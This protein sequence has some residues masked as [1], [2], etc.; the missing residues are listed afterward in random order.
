MPRPAKKA[1]SH[2]HPYDAAITMYRGRRSDSPYWEAQIKLPNGK[3]V[4]RGTGVSDKQ[5]AEK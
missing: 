4:Y 1:V 2:K 3:L 5:Q